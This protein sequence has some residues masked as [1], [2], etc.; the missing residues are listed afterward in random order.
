MP[1][2][3]YRHIC[4]YPLKE[5]SEL[6]RCPGCGGRITPWNT[7]LADETMTAPFG[8]ADAAL[9]HLALWLKENHPALGQEMLKAVRQDLRHRTER[10]EDESVEIEW[11]KRLQTHL[12]E[13]LSSD[14]KR[15]FAGKD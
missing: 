5:G 8:S 13:T 11:M 7:N 12:A 2:Q 15:G 4:G 10:E 3:L 9:D 14:K 1:E 6:D